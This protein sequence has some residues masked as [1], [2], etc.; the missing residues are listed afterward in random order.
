MRLPTG[1]ATIKTPGRRKAVDA[2]HGSSASARSVAQRF[3]FETIEADLRRKV[4]LRLIAATMFVVCLVS[5]A[6]SQPAIGEGLSE[7]QR[8]CG[9][10][11]AP[12]NPWLIDYPT[13]RDYVPIDDVYVSME[14][15]NGQWTEARVYLAATYAY[16]GMVD[17]N[18][19]HYVEAVDGTTPIAGG[20]AFTADW[21]LVVSVN[22][23]DGLIVQSPYGNWTQHR[24]YVSDDDTALVRVANRYG[25]LFF[26]LN[27]ELLYSQYAPGLDS[28][29]L[30]AFY[31]GS[32][33]VDKA[34]VGVPKK[35][36]EI[37]STNERGRKMGA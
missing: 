11:S 16:V 1:W 3:P 13:Y 24:E 25:W 28:H 23:W 2:E 35:Q 4:M 34:L 26:Y 8:R 32:V 7:N 12:G 36:C 29:D 10:V 9:D 5:A 17:A 31:F 20:H 6:H 33:D 30:R 21:S 22:G 27:G 14:Q 19:I 37:Q 15:I 18:T